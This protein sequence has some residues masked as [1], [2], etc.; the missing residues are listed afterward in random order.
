MKAVQNINELKFLRKERKLKLKEIEELTGIKTNTFS[1]YESGDRDLSTKTIK[2]LCEF[3][4][5]S[6][7]FLLGINLENALVSYKG[8]SYYISKELLVEAKNKKAL[9]YV[10]N[11]RTILLNKFIGVKEEINLNKMI[12]LMDASLNK[13]VIESDNNLPYKEIY[14]EELNIP[15]RLSIDL[16]NKV[17]LLLV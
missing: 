17:K 15:K 10:D 16:I 6:A 11:K 5:V 13:S 3:F 9:A 8:K 7:D 14:K 2:L 4:E 1:R 12:E